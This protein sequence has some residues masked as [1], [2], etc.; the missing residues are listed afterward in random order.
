MPALLDIE[1]AFVN[2]GYFS[3]AHAAKRKGKGPDIVKW[4]SNMLQSRV[5]AQLGSDRETKYLGIILDRKLR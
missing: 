5:K 3:I 4:I 2:T 1:G